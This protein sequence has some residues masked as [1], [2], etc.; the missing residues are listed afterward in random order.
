MSYNSYDIFYSYKYSREQN[1]TGLHSCN[2]DW[3]K[4]SNRVVKAE[5][6]NPSE[7]GSEGLMNRS[8][9]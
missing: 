6:I 5:K 2:R 7:I 8:T 1:T 9:I 4:L 3:Y